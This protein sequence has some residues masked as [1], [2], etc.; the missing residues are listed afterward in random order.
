MDTF[1]YKALQLAVRAHDGQYRRGVRV[2]YITH[3]IAVSAMATQNM[4][5]NR[6]AALC[7]VHDVLEDTEVTYADL[8]AELDVQLA[9]DVV[10]LTNYKVDQF[11][12][13]A[14]RKAA[15]AK[16]LAKAP[17][18]VQT[19]KCWDMYHNLSD[20]RIEGSDFLSRYTDDCAMILS[21]LELCDLHARGKLLG[22]IQEIRST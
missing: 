16:R 3:P 17:W 14:A 21:H 9:D 20:M 8:C 11:K 7:F 4:K 6:V 18:H 10:W 12:N 5:S 22:L 13:R 1:A 2:P 15:D 19:V